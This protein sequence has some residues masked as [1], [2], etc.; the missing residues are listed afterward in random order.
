MSGL[1]P[2]NWAGLGVALISLA[3]AAGCSTDIASSDVPS[4]ATPMA[5][6]SP[7]ASIAASV[8]PS[9]T[10]VPATANIFGAGHDELPEPGGGGDGTEPVEIPLTPG[11]G[12]K[13]SIWDAEGSVIPIADLGLANGPEGAGYGITDIESYGGISGILHRSNTMFLVGVFLTGEEPA[14]PAPERL[15]FSESEE[16]ETFEPDIAQTFLIGDGNG[17]T[18]VVP[19][20]ASRLF[21]GFADAASFAGQPGYYGNNSGAVRIRV[22]VTAGT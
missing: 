7:K 15:D 3:L 17:R 8:D 9:L 4:T 5:S 19:E 2:A 1:V 13:V 20:E 6:A 21:L 16:F 10:E 12:R 18:F 14:D 11:T 22:E